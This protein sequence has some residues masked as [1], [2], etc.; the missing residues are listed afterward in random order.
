MCD[1]FDGHYLLGCIPS[2]A[3][4]LLEDFLLRYDLDTENRA[5][6]LWSEQ[7]V[8]L[9]TALPDL[10]STQP[11]LDS[12]ICPPTTTS[13]PPKSVQSVH[14]LQTL[15]GLSVSF[16]TVLDLARL[17]FL[18]RLAANLTASNHEAANIP[19]Q[20]CLVNAFPSLSR[21]MVKTESPTTLLQIFTII[22]LHRLPALRVLHLWC[23]THIPAP[24]ANSTLEKIEALLSAVAHC[25]QLRRLVVD[26]RIAGAVPKVSRNLF[27][28]LF[29]LENLEQV[30]LSSD[31]AIDDIH[32]AEIGEAWRHIKYLCIQGPE[33]IPPKR[34]TYADILTI[35]GICPL[36]VGLSLH[37]EECIPNPTL[38]SLL[39]SGAVLP[40]LS[41]QYLVL[42]PPAAPL[43]RTYPELARFLCLAFPSLH[44][45]YSYRRVVTDVCMGLNEIAYIEVSLDRGRQHL[46]EDEHWVQINDVIHKLQ[47]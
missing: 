40:A 7:V 5:R 8:P 12:L 19:L 39:Q 42:I 15:S 20:P 27:R 41:I 1:L 35:C 34:F 47:R 2:L 18:D 33:D 30:V 45:I 6:S 10:C 46:D 25:S 3:G 26:I 31:I 22:S 9:Q 37:L 4:S 11:N 38:S 14:K 13:L 36:L 16:A 24:S 17:P 21:M 44:G 43:P 32:L 28:P 23:E 29:R